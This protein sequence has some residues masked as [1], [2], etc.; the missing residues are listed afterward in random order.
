MK[1]LRQ[2]FVYRCGRVDM[3]T[4]ASTVTE[5][6]VPI[7]GGPHAPGTEP[8]APIHE[9]FS[10]RATLWLDTKYYTLNADKLLS[11]FPTQGRTFCPLNLGRIWDCT[12]ELHVAILAACN[13]NRV[14]TVS[15]HPPVIPPYY[16]FVGKIDT[17]EDVKSPQDILRPG[18]LR[19]LSL[20]TL[21][22]VLCQKSSFWWSRQA[23]ASALYIEF[24]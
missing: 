10:L 20:Q 7:N 9:I 14:S 13:C 4:T 18:T 23:Q 8:F 5:A 24:S 17:M 15:H 2:S 21:P 12:A 11:N 6:A 22:K 16:H 1:R 3:R 19:G